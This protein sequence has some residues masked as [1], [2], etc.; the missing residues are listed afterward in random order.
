VI[1][2]E[3]FGTSAK[4][5]KA[6]VSAFLGVV[7]GAPAVVRE[8]KSRWRMEGESKR[9]E[10]AEKRRAKLEERRRRLEARGVVVDPEEAGD[11]EEAAV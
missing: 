1:A 3:Q 4:A 5:L 11:G 8:K 10:R 7:R 9:R 6:G 2:R